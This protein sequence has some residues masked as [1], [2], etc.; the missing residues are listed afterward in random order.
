MGTGK[1]KQKNSRDFLIVDE[2]LGLPK[3]T[4]NGLIR[5]QIWCDAEGNVTRYSLAYINSSSCREDNGRVLGYD[6]EHGYHHKHYFGKI[7]PF[8]FTSFNELE[9]LFK[10][11]F[12]M[13]YEK[14]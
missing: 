14:S 11:E 7:T 5:R 12:E 6:N 9:E 13:L 2:S 1:N 8:N 4:G 10:Q 3:K